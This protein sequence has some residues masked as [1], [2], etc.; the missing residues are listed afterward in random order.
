MDGLILLHMLLRLLTRILPPKFFGTAYYQWH[1]PEVAPEQWQKTMMH[2]KNTNTELL[3]PH[4]L[5][6]LVR[7]TIKLG[8]QKWEQN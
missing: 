1:E 2:H 6:S 8:K 5:G 7:F 4:L 3:F